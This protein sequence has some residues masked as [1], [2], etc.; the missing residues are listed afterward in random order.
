MKIKAG[1]GVKNVSQALTQRAFDAALRSGG[2][3][4]TFPHHFNDLNSIIIR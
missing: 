1:L 2:K 3:S 4:E